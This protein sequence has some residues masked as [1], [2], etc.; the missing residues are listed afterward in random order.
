MISV[1]GPLHNNETGFSCAVYEIRSH[2]SGGL[3]CPQNGHPTQLALYS[4]GKLMRGRQ[5]QIRA[6]IITI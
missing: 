6:G 3:L 2:P 4:A 1:Y 5:R